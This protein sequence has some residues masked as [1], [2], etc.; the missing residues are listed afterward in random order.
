MNRQQ[1]NLLDADLLP[2]RQQLPSSAILLLPLVVLVGLLAMYGHSRWKLNDLRHQL[3][4]LTDQETVLIT[5]LEQTTRTFPRQEKDPELERRIQVLADEKA[6]KVRV[7]ETLKGRTLSNTEGFAGQLEAIANQW[8]EGLWMKSLTI[9]DAGGELRITGFAT[10][11][12]QPPNLVAS[13]GKSAQLS[14]TGF[15]TF[16][17]TRGK[18]ERGTLRFELDTRRVEPEPEEENNPAPQNAFGLPAGGDSL[19]PQVALRAL[20]GMTQ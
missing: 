17:I 8:P 1:V 13:L 18:D 6:L 11:A 3:T 20:Q 7:L 14:G 9:A 5:Q 19:S 10:A 4:T 2:K 15:R 12:V 16:R